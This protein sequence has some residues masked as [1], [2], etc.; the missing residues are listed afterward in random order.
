MHH[1]LPR[2]FV[3][4]E[5]YPGK[6][7]MDTKTLLDSIGG[8]VRH[9][10]NDTVNTCAI[11]MSWCL[12]KSG[13]PIARL[14]NVSVYEGMKAPSD[15][16]R[17]R[18]PSG[19]LYIVSATKMKVYLDAVY[20]EGQLIYDARKEPQRIHLG[21]RK[22]VQ[23]I[24]MFD[25]LGRPKDFGATGHVDLFLVLDNGA[26]AKPQFVPACVGHCYWQEY[27]QPMVAYLWE[28]LP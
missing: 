14:P 17:H 13:Q 3:L 24:V 21:G 6:G 1:E 26:G 18:Q 11:R 9:T 20:G 4:R 28:A 16:R 22:V 10:F 25:W 8:Q 2:F 19:D 23:G 7:S 12:I 27:K 15:P 5:C